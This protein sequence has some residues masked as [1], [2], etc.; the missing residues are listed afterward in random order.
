MVLLLL[1]DFFVCLMSYS[2]QL[3]FNHHLN[4]HIFLLQK[5]PIFIQL[6][7]FILHFLPH[8]G[9]FGKI[10]SFNHEDKFYLKNFLL[11]EFLLLIRYLNRNLIEILLRYLEIFFDVDLKRD[12]QV[13]E[14]FRLNWNF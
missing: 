6:K 2:D 1:F 9:L 5:I 3:Y 4:H 14:H 10:L 13:V 11:E 7:F 8:F 12:A